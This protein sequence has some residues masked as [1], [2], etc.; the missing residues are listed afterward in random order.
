[1][2]VENVK[3]SMILKTLGPLILSCIVIQITL[4]TVMVISQEDT[5]RSDFGWYR[6]FLVI[7]A[8]CM[9]FSITDVGHAKNELYT[10]Q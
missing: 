9:C 10:V 1:M 6:N 5:I 8:N 4:A 7:F 3:A 2:D